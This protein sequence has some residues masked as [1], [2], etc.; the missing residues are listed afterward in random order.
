M[1]Q[2]NDHLFTSAVPVAVCVIYMKPHGVGVQTGGFSA[3]ILH[4][5]AVLGST[6]FPPHVTVSRVS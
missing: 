6:I 4:Y 5:L 2:N 1:K 3:Y